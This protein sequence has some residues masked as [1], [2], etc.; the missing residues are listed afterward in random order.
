MKFSSDQIEQLDAK[1]HPRYVKQNQDGQSYIEAWVVIH[2][3]NAIFGF[4]GWSSD[5]TRIEIADKLPYKKGGTDMWEVTC[6]ATV[7]VTAG[8]VHHDGVGTG[9]GFGQRISGAIDSAIKEAESDALK[10]ALR[11][12]GNQFGNAL[13]DKDKRFVGE[14]EPRQKPAPQPT[15]TEREEGPN[16][17]SADRIINDVIAAQ[18][19]ADV[20][21]IG[22]RE[23]NFIVSL[24]SADRSRIQ[25]AI[26]AQRAALAVAVGA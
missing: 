5:T 3:A 8:G 10:R 19:L 6:F 4:D 1:L 13:Y 24:P 15:R 11:Q 26:A 14:T 16:P 18:T 20:E 23:A 12:F 2:R 17:T 7:R 22:K 9:S 21:A 25:K